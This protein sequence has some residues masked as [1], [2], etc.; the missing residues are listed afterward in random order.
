MKKNLRARLDSM[1]SNLS[2]VRNCSTFFA[3]VVLI[4][5]SNQGLFAQCDVNQKYDKI[6]SGY[7]G[8]IT[9]K[10]DG[11]YSCWGQ[12]MKSDGSTDALVPQDINSTNYTALGSATIYKAAIGGAGGGGN[13]QM[14]LL[15]ST[16]IFAWG[17]KGNV[18]KTTLTNVNTFG[19]ITAPTGG[20]GSTTL[21]LPTG[22]LPTD[23]Q[24]MFATYQTLVLVTKIVNNVGGNVYVLTQTTLAVEANGGVATT[25]GS[26]SCLL[27]TSPSPRD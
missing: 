6:M 11:T 13:D 12:T 16:G 9:L 25:A 3:I 18:L 7:H 19:N 15:T 17:G 22:V 20:I 5:V 26:S 24:T 10:N 8:S 14:I 2:F 21:D 23:V 1:L 4:I 27:Y